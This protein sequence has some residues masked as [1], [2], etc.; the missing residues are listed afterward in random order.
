MDWESN[1]LEISPCT[2][3]CFLATGRSLYLSE[4]SFLLSVSSPLLLPF[5]NKCWF[6]R[7]QGTSDHQVSIT[8]EAFPSIHTSTSHSLS[9]FCSCVENVCRPG[10][11]SQ[12]DLI[13]SFVYAFLENL[14][15]YCKLEA[16]RSVSSAR[17]TCSVHVRTRLFPD[18]PGRC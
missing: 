15:M 6:V 13:I 18:C 14:D 17:S 8:W 4:V 7:V 2:T 12:E 11:V 9:R 1:E 16:W 3:S 10:K 5:L